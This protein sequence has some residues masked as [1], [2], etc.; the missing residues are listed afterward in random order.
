V[1][2]PRLLGAA[3]TVA[4]MAGGLVLIAAGP[5]SACSC[6]GVRS[7]AERAARADAVFVGEL[8]GRRVHPLA[9]VGEDNMRRPRRAPFVFT[10]K[11]SR[12][13]KGVVSERQEIVTPGGAG[14][15]C[16]GLGIGVRGPGP[17]LVFAYQ[18]SNALY[19]LS[20]GQY[21]SSLCSGSRALAD[22]EPALGGLPAYEPSWP[23]PAG[24]V[25]GV[26]VLA[27]VVVAGVA[28]VRGRRRAGAG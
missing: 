20:L 4:V 10:F 3:L 23:P 7:E 26:K 8:V 27:V 15:S 22:G 12:V 19:P 9:W 17:F 1:K 6:A 5:A 2:I 21:G 11:V 28:I 14:G 16:G 18:S 25:V 24:L 13:Y